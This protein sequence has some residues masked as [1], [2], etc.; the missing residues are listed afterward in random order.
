MEDKVKKK[1]R[2]KDA[3]VQ[4]KIELYRDIAKSRERERERERERDRDRVEEVEPDRRKKWSCT[5]SNSEF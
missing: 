4:R 5:D 3:Q 2:K 1:E